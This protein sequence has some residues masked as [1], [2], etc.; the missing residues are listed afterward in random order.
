MRRAAPLVVVLGMVF[1]FTGHLL[2]CGDKFLRIG[3]NA[4]AGRY[5]AVYPGS[6]LLYQLPGSNASLVKDLERIVRASGHKTVSVKTAADARAA[7]ASGQFDIVLAGPG[8]VPTALQLTSGGRSAPDLVPILYKPSKAELATAHHQYE[9]LIAVPTDHKNRALA[10]ID[11]RMEL[12]VK[13]TRR[14]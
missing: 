9:C 14:G 11:C 1:T 3:H 12:R 8:E 7:L 6:V 4:R 10:A 2:A 13:P 5:V